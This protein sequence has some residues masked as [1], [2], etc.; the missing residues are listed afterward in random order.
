M[1]GIFLPF[2]NAATLVS[3]WCSTPPTIDGGIGA[4]E[5]DAAY[6]NSF[7]VYDESSGTPAK[8]VAMWAMNDIDNLYLRFQW[9]DDTN[10]AYYDIIVIYFDED[11]NGNWSCDGVENY[12]MLYLN[13][14]GSIFT[15][16]YISIGCGCGITDLVSQDGNGSYSYDSGTKSYTVEFAIPI[17]SAYSEDLQ[18]AA[19]DLL[20]IGIEITDGAPPSKGYCYPENLTSYGVV[21]FQLASPPNAVGSFFILVSIICAITFLIYTRLKPESKLIIL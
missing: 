15:D 7:Y 19:G 2:S 1:A 16:G 20:G 13:S 10:D 14:T 5:W 6:P 11:N 12:V 9:N 8:L 3:N 21:T 17:G 4:G 18:P